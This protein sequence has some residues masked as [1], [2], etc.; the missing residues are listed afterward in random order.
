MGIF[1]TAAPPYAAEMAPLVIRGSIS[2]GMNFAIVL[3]QLIGYGVVRQTSL[4][5]DSR[6]YKVL[7]ASQWGFCAVGLAVLP[8]F[9]EFVFPTPSQVHSPLTR[10]I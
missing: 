5:G 3:G 10:S 8:F 2:A 7:F 1:T 4:Y 9:P 6:S